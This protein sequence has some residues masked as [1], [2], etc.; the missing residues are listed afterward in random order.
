M[1]YKA[2]GVAKSCLKN[3]MPEWGT[4]G[5]VGDLAGNRRVY[6]AELDSEVILI[7]QS[8]GG[9]TAVMSL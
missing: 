4:S 8:S 9:T 3:R 5:P 7:C 6:P 1:P 2:C